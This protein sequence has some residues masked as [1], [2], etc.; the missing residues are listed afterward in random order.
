MPVL[1]AYTIT[2]NHLIKFRN[3][4]FFQGCSDLLLALYIL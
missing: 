3:K 1:S 2:T 4:Q